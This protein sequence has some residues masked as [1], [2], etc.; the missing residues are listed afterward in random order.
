[1]IKL[2]IDECLSAELVLMA[3]E[4][5][6]HESSHV[7]WIGKSGWK[8]WELKKVLLD[9]DWVLVTWNCKDFCGPKNAVGSKGVCLRTFHSMPANP[10]ARRISRKLPWGLL[11]GPRLSLIKN[12]G[13]SAFSRNAFLR[14]LYEASAFTVVGWSGTIRDLPNLLSRI[15]ISPSAKFTSLFASR[16]ASPLR[17]PVVAS[18]PI[19][20]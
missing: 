12:L 2:L 14:D 15:V 6:H 18:N 7:V 16:T 4:R 3:R 1:M 19:R 5:G 17:M 13:A 20:W 10:A 8:D 9:E 11:I